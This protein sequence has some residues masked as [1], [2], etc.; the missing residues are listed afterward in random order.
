MSS[1][2]HTAMRKAIKCEL[3][4]DENRSVSIIIINQHMH[5]KPV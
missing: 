2:T 4:S 1:A 5:M 3:K